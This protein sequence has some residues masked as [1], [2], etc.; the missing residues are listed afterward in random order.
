MQARCLLITFSMLVSS[1]SFAQKPGET[2]TVG[3]EPTVAGIPTVKLTFV[4]E[5]DAPRVAASQVVYGYWGCSPDGAIFL[6]TASPSHLGKSAL[7]S[8]A[9]GHGG[10]LGTSFPLETIPDLHDGLLRSYFATES[11]VVVLMDA[12][13]DDALSMTKRVTV[14]PSTGERFERNIKSGTRH[15]YLAT[16]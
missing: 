11:E 6:E 10:Y 3:R 16:F 9:A 8:I 14:V 1:L 7:S 5:K 4:E 13:P 15:D 12:T 2:M